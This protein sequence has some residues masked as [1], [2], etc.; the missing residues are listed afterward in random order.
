M[1]YIIHIVNHEQI[2]HSYKREI[3]EAKE[4]VGVSQQKIAL[5]LKSVITSMINKDLI[6]SALMF[7]KKKG[8]KDPTYLGVM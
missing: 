3:D 4:L 5:I 1:L 6:Q 7:Y 2:W 8:R